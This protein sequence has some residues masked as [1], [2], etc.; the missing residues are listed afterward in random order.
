MLER[1]ANQAMA[2]YVKREK[3]TVVKEGGKTYIMGYS[4]LG[5]RLEGHLAHWSNDWN[6]VEFDRLNEARNLA[7]AKILQGLG[8]LRGLVKTDLPG[9]ID[10]SLYT[11]RAEKLESDVIGFWKTVP[12]S[13]AV[14][15]RG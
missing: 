8:M 3:F 13:L 14:I 1:A 4:T 5:G 10:W 7:T 6:D 11:N 2:N 15:S 9:N 12:T